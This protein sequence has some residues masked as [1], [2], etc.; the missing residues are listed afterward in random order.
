MSLKV[1][2][3]KQHSALN[4]CRMRWRGREEGGVILTVNWWIEFF[5]GELVV[6]ERMTMTSRREDKKKNRYESSS[7]ILAS[8]SSSFYYGCLWRGLWL[9]LNF[10]RHRYRR[11][12][13]LSSSRGTSG[14]LTDLGIPE[15]AP[16][17]GLAFLDYFN[18]QISHIKSPN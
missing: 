4:R 7:H 14:F 18:F 9:R 1:Y 11:P 15:T 17:T 12:P 8:P 13:K 3:R 5:G 2:I 16:S 6:L 10:G